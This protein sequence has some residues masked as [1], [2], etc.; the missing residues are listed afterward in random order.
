[1]ENDPRIVS[2]EEVRREA[3]QSPQVELVM[4]AEEVSR[5]FHYAGIPVS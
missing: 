5:E 2:P 1:M 4:D 3:Y